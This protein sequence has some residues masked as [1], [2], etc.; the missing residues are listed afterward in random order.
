MRRLIYLIRK[1][2]G[3]VRSNLAFHIIV[4]LMPIMFLC[5]W[6]LALTEDVTLPVALAGA[7][8]DPGFADHLATYSTPSGTPYFDVRET[9]ASGNDP[10][11]NVVRLIEPIEPTDTGGVIGVVELDV[12][13][14]DRNLTKNFRNRLTGAVTSYVE[15]GFLD[16][17][18]VNI[19]EHLTHETEVPWTHF[20]VTSIL[21][22]GTL[23][24]A[25]L[26]GALSLSA[27]WS[28]GVM[29]FL[30]TA[31]ANPAWILAAKQ[32]GVLLKGAVSCGM[33]LFV[34]SLM[35]PGLG[36]PV[37]VVM[38]I[39]VAGYW[40]IGPIGMAVGTVIKD[41][42]TCFLI[43][44]LS[45]IG[46]WLLG[47]GFGDMTLLGSTAGQVAAYNPAAHLLRLVQ[48]VANG[49]PVDLSTTLPVLALWFIAGQVLV[50]IL[51]LNRIHL[52][53]RR[54]G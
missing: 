17:S 24:G 21:I 40:V 2:L 16:G 35:V 20:F 54:R 15:A 37:G 45:S 41:P 7:E 49:S 1:E 10:Q 42:I 47:N 44:L 18:G 23:M 51:Y 38:V 11:M 28:S 8:T 22:L 46:F 19:R 53:Q 50:V 5:F 26:F 29:T 6:V 33:A 25:M 48:H 30:H 13:S 36:L 52:P 9:P 27:E 3:G 39:C 43:S 34:A 32:L 14:I 31:P 12:H 4:A